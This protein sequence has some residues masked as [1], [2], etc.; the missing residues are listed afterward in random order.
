[1]YLQDS[2][3]ISFG[4]ITRSGTAG[5]WDSSIFSLLRMVHIQFS[6]MALPT[7]IPTDSVKVSFSSLLPKLFIS[8]LLEVVVNKPV[9]FFWASRGEG[10][11]SRITEKVR[12]V[13]DASLLQADP[14]ICGK[15]GK[16]F[17]LHR[18]KTNSALALRNSGKRQLTSMEMQGEV[19]RGLKLQPGKSQ[20]CK[21][22]VRQCV[23]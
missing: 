11:S 4:Y 12:V 2:D 23:S 19:S 22:R 6:I 9:Y 15:R 21:V 20:L 13:T 18:R 10:F 3:F 17:L 16:S 5:S 14:G 7:Y 8:G 1:M